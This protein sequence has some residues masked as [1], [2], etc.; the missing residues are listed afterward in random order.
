MLL[1]DLQRN[2][3]STHEDFANL[4]QA[5]E[6]IKALTIYVNEQ[7]RYENIRTKRKER[8]ERRESNL[9]LI[10]LNSLAEDLATLQAKQAII[11]G[12]GC[13]NLAVQYPLL[14]LP[15]PLSSLSLLL[16]EDTGSSSERANSTSER[17]TA[18]RPRTDTC[19]SSMTSSSSLRG[20]RTRTVQS[21]TTRIRCNF[22]CSAWRMIPVCVSLWSSLSLFSPL[23][24]LPSP[25]SPLPSPLSP[26][27]SP[28]SPL[29]SPSPSPSPLP[30]L[31]SI[32]F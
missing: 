13:P 23:S 29:P 32:Y 22:S 12:K 27:P 18:S 25:L 10:L 5:V 3:L 28:L 31:S 21:I 24:P 16:S 9:L 7:K 19:S 20:R 2:T 14:S 26:L 15:F 11:K 6:R 30:S 4:T 17:T 1:T 8:E